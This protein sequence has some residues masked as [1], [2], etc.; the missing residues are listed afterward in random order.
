MTIQ[1]NHTI[2]QSKNAELSAQFLT[3][4]LS[5]PSPTRF[6]PFVVVKTHNDVCLDFMTTPKEIQPRHFA[7]LIS[8]TEFDEVLARI[9]QKKLM[10]WADHKRKQAE[11]INHNDGG[12]GCYFLDP[13][14]HFLEI[15][16]RPYGSG[17]QI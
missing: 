12:R 3:E 4:I 8:E 9:I 17:A 10:Y 5:L 11:Q 15:L 6:G 13:N 14:G 1:F 2:I 16:T 7:F